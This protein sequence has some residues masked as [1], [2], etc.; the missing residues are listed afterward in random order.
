MVRC[1]NLCYAMIEQRMVK[2]MYNS[3]DYEF[4]RFLKNAAET[5][6]PTKKILE[7]C[8]LTF[9]EA[10]EK[11]EKYC[12]EFNTLVKKYNVTA[13][14]PDIVLINISDALESNHDED[15]IRLCGMAIIDDGLLFGDVEDEEERVL[16]WA[17]ANDKLNLFMGYMKKQPVYKERLEKLVKSIKSDIKDTINLEEQ[18]ALYTM[19]L[20]HDFIYKSGKNNT[21]LMNIG[22]LVRIVNSNEMLKIIKP[23]VYSAVLCRKHKMMLEREEYIPN[24]KDIF[25]FK[26]YKIYTDNGKNFNTY[27]SYIEL[28]EH[29]RRY[30]LDD[31]EVDIDFSDYCFASLSN[32]CDW[33]CLNCEPDEDIPRGFRSSIA[34]YFGKLDLIGDTLIGDDYYLEDFIEENPVMEI[35]LENTLDS[36]FDILQE[37]FDARYNNESTEK[38]VEKFF[39]LS[40]IEK[41]NPNT[42]NAKKYAEM[43]LLEQTEVSI[44]NVLI[45]SLEE[46]LK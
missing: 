33:F 29:L 42:E 1:I 46:M 18:S 24:I 32:L 26:E 22:E 6:N 21:Y 9:D 3:E 16:Q 7:E 5:Y 34:T 11:T 20:E 17:I 4:Y 27:Q 13:Q 12:A 8:N 25:K 23:Y 36:N 45:D 31:R 44:R 40:G 19:S 35:A 10:L 37:F 38:I 41:M 28:Y 39:N 15:M 14:T 2:N 43:F 30:Y